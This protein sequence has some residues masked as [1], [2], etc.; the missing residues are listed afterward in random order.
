[1]KNDT[2]VTRNTVHRECRLDSSVG[3]YRMAK[4]SKNSDEKELR[5]FPELTDLMALLGHQSALQ[6]GLGD[7]D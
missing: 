7:L 2:I 4:P 5:T 1:M 3:E 6:E